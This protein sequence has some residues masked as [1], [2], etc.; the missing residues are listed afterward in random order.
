MYIIKVDIFVTP[1]K[2]MND[3]LI[4]QLFFKD[5][6]VLKEVQNSFFDVK[7]IKFSY[8][9]LLIFK[10]SLVLIYQCVSFIN[11]TSD[12]IE[13]RGVSISSTFLKTS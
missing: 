5:E 4:S 7:M 10:I 11:Y 13:N 6:D 8:H 12:I 2:I 1:F 9:S 3:T